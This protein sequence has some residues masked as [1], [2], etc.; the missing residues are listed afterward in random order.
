MK[1]NGG[2]E[3]KFHTRPG[4]I[5]ILIVARFDERAAHFTSLWGDAWKKGWKRGAAEKEEEEEEDKVYGRT[6]VK[7]D[8]VAYRRSSS[9]IVPITSGSIGGGPMANKY[10]PNV[11]T[12]PQ[13]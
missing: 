2:F 1:Q 4:G 13:D 3:V 9:K 7:R 6:V 8:E 12:L 5:C 11:Y 10:M